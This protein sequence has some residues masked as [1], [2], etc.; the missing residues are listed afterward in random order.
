MDYLV[1]NRGVRTQKV[2]NIATPFYKKTA[3]NAI[4]INKKH[5]L[6]IS[7]ASEQNQNKRYINSPLRS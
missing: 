3:S 5:S 2:S 7:Y 4:N 1:A 6:R